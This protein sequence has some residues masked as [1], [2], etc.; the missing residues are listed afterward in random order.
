VHLKEHLV[1]GDVKETRRRRRSIAVRQAN[2]IQM[3]QTTRLGRQI[4]V[5]LGLLIMTG[6]AVVRAQNDPQA[7]IAKK[8]AELERQ[9]IELEKKSLDLKQRELDLE[10]ARQE[11]QAQQS[12]RSLSINLSGDVLFDYDKATLKVDAEESLKK[13]AVVLSQFPESEVTVE[14]Y[15]DSKGSKAFNLQ[16]SRERAQA[17]KDWLVKNGNVLAAHIFT[18]GLGEEFAIAPNTGADGSDNPLGRALNRRVSIIVEKPAT[19][20]IPT[21]TPVP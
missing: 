12:G 9:R 17:V 15:T 7:V 20:A 6:T 8:Q 19:T 11:F 5:S 4:V 2:L 1:A 13:V 16:L 18:K 10:K 14:G 21:V 3:K